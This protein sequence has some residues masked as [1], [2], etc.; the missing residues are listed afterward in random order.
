M[1]SCLLKDP[2]DI[3]ELQTSK[4]E[5]GTIKTEYVLKYHTRAFNRFNSENQVVS[6]GEI[7]YPISRTFIVREYVP[8]VET[9][10]ILWDGKWWRILSINK[11]KYYNNIE[12]NTTVVND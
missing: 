12:I 4:T 6:E 11:N 1:K 10:R 8:I 2:I 7:Y 9:D 3:Y 5:Y